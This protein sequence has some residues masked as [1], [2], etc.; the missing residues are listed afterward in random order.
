M[1]YTVMQYIRIGGF[2]PRAMERR[3]EVMDGT[4]SIVFALGIGA[5]FAVAC[6]SG[7]EGDGE[8]RADTEF[9]DV[10]RMDAV[11]DSSGDDV[12]RVEVG[13]QSDTADEEDSTDSDAVDGGGE[14]D[15]DTGDADGGSS[16]RVLVPE[17]TYSM[18]CDDADCDDDEEPVHAVKISQFYLDKTE[19]SQREYAECVDAGAC[20]APSEGTYNPSQRPD[21]PVTGVTWQQA[22][23][24]CD[25]RGGRLPTEAEWEMACTGGEE[26]TYPWGSF[27][28]D[29]EMANLG[30]CD[31]DLVE[32]ESMERGASPVGALHMAGNAWEWT[33]DWY[34]AEAYTSH[35]S[36]NP[37]GPSS[38][39]KRVYR[40]GSA[41]NAL[42]LAR[43]QNRASTYSPDT[44]GSGLGFRCAYEES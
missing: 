22:T 7:S 14:L 35:D 10:S 26:R 21:I 30:D 3:G 36:E 20:E 19:V 17:G 40:G 43:C 8:S 12:K 15:G 18:G 29:C 16:E 9:A 34:D 27:E 6:S 24:Y 23:E 41:G 4:N 28:P 1:Q 2:T 33:A 44:G 5:F 13:D 39:T 25:F 32:V 11:V 31:G 38:G 42:S 37:T